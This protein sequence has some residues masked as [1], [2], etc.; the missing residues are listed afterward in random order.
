MSKNVVM[1]HATKHL[2]YRRMARIF[3]PL[4]MVLARATQAE[5]A[6]MVDYLKTQNRILRSNLPNRVDLTPAERERLVARGKPLGKKIKELITIVTPR[7]F[8]R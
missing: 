1:F 7:T 6:Q 8:A 4:F 2:G 5:L 3:H